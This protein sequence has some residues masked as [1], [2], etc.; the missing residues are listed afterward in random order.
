M[1]MSIVP[2]LTAVSHVAKI[3]ARMGK[4]TATWRLQG[5]CCGARPLNRNMVPVGQ[6]IEDLPQTKSIMPMCE[7]PVN[8][9]RRC[10][11]ATCHWL[12][13]AI[14]VA[15]PLQLFDA[16][17]QQRERPPLLLHRGLMA[18]LLYEQR[19]DVLLL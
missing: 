14:I 7:S 9:H 4:G 6:V 16:L 3:S 8:L 2:V 10:T 17:K 12:A 13:A 11:A 15:N 18:P 19:L 5:Q 1:H